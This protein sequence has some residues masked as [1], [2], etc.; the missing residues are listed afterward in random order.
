MRRLFAVVRSQGQWDRT[1]PLEQQDGWA[2]HAQ[3]MD[4]LQEEGFIALGGPLQGTEDVL[5]IVRADNAAEITAHLAE[6]CWSKSGQLRIS[7]IAPW[8]LRLGSLA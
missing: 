7:R 1:R 8:E 3:F 6:D 4:G 2:A 5:L